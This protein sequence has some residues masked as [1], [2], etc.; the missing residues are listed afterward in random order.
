MGLLNGGRWELFG[1]WPWVFCFFVCV[2]LRNL[3]IFFLGEWISST[4]RN[5][6]PSFQIEWSHFCNPTQLWIFSLF[7]WE[8]HSQMS[9]IPF[10]ILHFL[11]VAVIKIWNHI[12]DS[13]D[14]LGPFGR[15]FDETAFHYFKVSL[16]IKSVFTSQATLHSQSKNWI[17]TTDFFQIGSNQSIQIGGC[18]SCYWLLLLW[19]LVIFHF[20]T[21]PTEVPNMTKLET[22]TGWMSEDC[23][24][25]KVTVSVLPLKYRC[26]GIWHFRFETWK[27]LVSRVFLPWDSQVWNWNIFGTRGETGQEASPW[28]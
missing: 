20:V 24:S 23:T 7:H 16:F 3:Y 25:L 2:L 14:I 27:L 10:A 19:R 5:G 26:F 9:D 8:I 18:C 15:H 1:V 28:R 17:G 6:E 11:R 12:P 22:S 4:K 13:W 21:T